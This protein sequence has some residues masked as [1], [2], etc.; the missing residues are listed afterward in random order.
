MLEHGVE[1]AGVPFDES[2]FPGA[3]TKLG[4]CFENAAKLAMSHREL[5]YVEGYATSFIPLH[6]AWCVTKDGRVV[7]PTWGGENYPGELAIEGREYFGVP[8]PID[9]VRRVLVESETWGVFFKE[10]WEIVRD[11]FDEEEEE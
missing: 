8:V 6:H 2:E 9:L 3:S 7:D 10:E 5:T 4:D 11:A 1:Y